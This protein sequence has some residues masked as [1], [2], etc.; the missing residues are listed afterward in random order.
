[1]G[2]LL[3]RLWPL[4]QGCIAQH[5]AAARVLLA[6]A[7]WGHGGVVPETQRLNALLEMGHALAEANHLGTWMVAED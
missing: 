2:C 4:M 7:L 1:M 5:R 3:L 6:L